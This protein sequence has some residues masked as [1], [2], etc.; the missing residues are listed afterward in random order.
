MDGSIDGEN[1][2]HKLKKKVTKSKR[3]LVENPLND[4]SGDEENPKWVDTGEKICDSCGKNTAAE[5]CDGYCQ[6][7]WDED[8]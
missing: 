3:V 5:G 7:C 8:E 6:K 2:G 4:D 1:A